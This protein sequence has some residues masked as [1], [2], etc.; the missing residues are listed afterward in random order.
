MLIFSDNIGPRLQYIAAFAA[1][2]LGLPGH[3]LTTDEEEYSR[4]TGPRIN[5][6]S[7][8]QKG[9]KLRIHPHGL[10]SE[11]GI[12]SRE[13]SC[14]QVGDHKAFFATGGDFPFD[15]FAASFYLLSRYEEYLP[16]QKDMYGRFSHEQSV[17]FREGFLNMPV[18]NYWFKDLRRKL[19]QLFT[20]VNFTPATFTFLPTYDI[21]EAYAY[22]HK[23]LIRTWGGKLR[24]MIR[25]NKEE[26][27]LRNEVLSGKV[28]DPYDSFDE[29]DKINRSA[30]LQPVYFFLVPA[31]TGRY[32]RNISPRTTAMRNLI[33]RHSQKYQLGVHPSW[34]SGDDAA[35]V[36]NEIKYLGELTGKKIVASRQH[37]IRFTLPH[38]FRELEQA[39]I[40]EE[41]SM[42]YGSINGFRA[43]VA[44]P[45][46]FFYL[47]VERIS[48][49]LLYPFCFM[50]ANSCFEQGFTPE[51]A[52]GE[53]KHYYKVT[54]EAAGILVMIWH[55]TFLGTAERFRGWKE[56][57]V[58]FL[59]EIGPG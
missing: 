47:E 35:L 28:L 1:S 48:S 22:R 33:T 26:N 23:G 21:D 17:A 20:G 12:R 45:F 24:S 39:G 19:Q 9:D 36:R 29:M 37:F 31:R 30:R 44:T 59:K 14:F 34:Q 58:E 4:Y 7:R 38:T 15:I 54:R 18:V 32:D 50:D 42:G 3:R 40:T 51:E 16:H 41:Y 55:N 6:S 49:L 10:L 2:E 27:K 13:I 56:A 5:Y 25:G 8:P 53:M 52:V 43:S 57:Y 46:L 11:T